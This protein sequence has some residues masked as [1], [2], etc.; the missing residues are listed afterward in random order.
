MQ[1]TCNILNIS[2]PAITDYASQDVLDIL[3][4]ID[5]AKLQPKKR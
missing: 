5:N 2:A 3:N 1:N 4:R